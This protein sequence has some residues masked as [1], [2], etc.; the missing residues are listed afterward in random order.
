MGSV[1]LFLQWNYIHST[2]DFI[3]ALEQNESVRTMADVN[4]NKERG[5]EAER[6]ADS[7][8]SLP[9]QLKRKSC[10][11]REWDLENEKGKQRKEILYP[12]LWLQQW[13]WFW[14]LVSSKESTLEKPDS[15]L[16]LP[17][18]DPWPQV[19]DSAFLS[20]YCFLSVLLV[21]VSNYLLSETYYIF[22]CFLLAY[23]VW[24]CFMFA[25]D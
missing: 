12:R 6:P 10:Y 5:R 4:R 3:I 18:W 23:F 15:Q 19:P 2:K 25:A 17:P 21:L 9:G 20:S 13:V 11:P 16:P 14:S 7:L 8:M 1:T 22:F 24:H